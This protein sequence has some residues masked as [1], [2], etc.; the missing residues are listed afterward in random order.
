MKCV[1]VYTAYEYMALEREP[2]FILFDESV[3]LIRRI[4]V[5]ICREEGRTMHSTCIYNMIILIGD[6]NEIEILMLLRG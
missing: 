4:L 5:W 2:Y 3:R 6:L 1:I